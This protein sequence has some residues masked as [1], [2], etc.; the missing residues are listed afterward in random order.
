MSYKELNVWKISMDLVVD[1][2][3]LTAT[4]PNS[5]LYGLTSQMRRA[6]VSIPSN[7]A[8]GSGR[9][10]KKEYIQ[11]IYI[12]K[13]SLSELETQIEIAHRLSFIKDTEQLYNN[14]K[15][16]RVMITNLIAYLNDIDNPKP[17]KPQTP[18]TL[19]P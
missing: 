16:I 4:F 2:Y 1:I 3:N 12:S 5:E 7:I 6:A 17:P 9:K 11:F 19:K 8:E 18:K 15:R 13:G 10:S 14:I